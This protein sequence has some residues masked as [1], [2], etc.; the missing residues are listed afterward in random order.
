MTDSLYILI[1][2]VRLI[3]VDYQG[4]INLIEESSGYVLCLG[5]QPEWYKEKF[6]TAGYKREKVHEF[7]LPLKRCESVDCLL[8]HQPWNRYSKLGDHLFNV[9]SNCKEEG[10]RALQNAG[11][12][13]ACEGK[14]KMPEGANHQLIPWLSSPQIAILSN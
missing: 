10:R 4:I 5:M 3:T 6:K 12:L 1:Q 11:S 8:W 9:C 14:L 2:V 13:I 7:Q